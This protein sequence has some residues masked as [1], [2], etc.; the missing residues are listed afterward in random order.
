MIKAY[1]TAQVLAQELL[2][3]AAG[4][5]PRI[6]ADLQM[7]AAEVSAEMIEENK[8]KTQASLI[9][10]LLLLAGK[11]LTD[12]SFDQKL[13]KFARLNN[14]SLRYTFIFSIENY[15]KGF[16]NALE[17]LRQNGFVVPPNRIWNAWENVGT[18]RDTGYRGINITI[19]SSQKQRFELQ[20]HTEESFRMKTETHRFY[21]ELR[22]IK[23]SDERRKEIIKEMLEL[24]KKIT[25]PEG[26]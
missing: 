3:Q 10:K 2:A 17:K 5:E 18:P 15:W 16:Q 12:K 4:N 24:A 9:R 26:I 6:T 1:R 13:R 25:R 8:F 22:N 21:E 7:I 19:I 20:F 11:D 14:D 23:T